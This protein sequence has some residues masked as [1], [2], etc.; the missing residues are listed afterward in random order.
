MLLLYYFFFFFFSVFCRCCHS[1]FFNFSFK[2]KLKERRKIVF[3]CWKDSDSGVDERVG[4]NKK[5]RGSRGC[6]AALPPS[7]STL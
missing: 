5:G 6:Y 4:K 1:Q 3:V 7:S 2:I